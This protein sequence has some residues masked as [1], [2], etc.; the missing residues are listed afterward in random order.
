MKHRSNTRHLTL[1]SKKALR[2]VLVIDASEW[3]K[4][5]HEIDEL[6]PGRARGLSR[7]E[8]LQDIATETGL[9][10]EQ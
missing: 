8:T 4:E 3:L 1:L 2:V 5:G 6:P 10:Y 7:Y 9:M